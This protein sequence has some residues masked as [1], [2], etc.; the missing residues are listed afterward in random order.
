MHGMTEGVALGPGPALWCHQNVLVVAYNTKQHKFTSWMREHEH[1]CIS[2]T[3]LRWCVHLVVHYAC[4]AYSILIYSLL[5]DLY[6]GPKLATDTS[7]C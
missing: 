4:M 7:A 5:I 2:N 3:M 1:K 6:L